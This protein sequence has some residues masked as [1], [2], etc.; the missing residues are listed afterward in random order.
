MRTWLISVSA[1]QLAKEQNNVENLSDSEGDLRYSPLTCCIFECPKRGENA[2]T[3]SCLDAGPQILSLSHTQMQ[4]PFWNIV[5]SK[6]L[7]KQNARKQTNYDF[8]K[9]ETLS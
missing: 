5:A 9:W 3:G 8:E 7:G 2:R 6:S 1:K 4:S